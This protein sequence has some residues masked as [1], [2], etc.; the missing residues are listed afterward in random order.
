MLLILLC[1]AV[2]V[3]PGLLVAR[4]AGLPGWT[5][6]GA[7]PLVSYGV[8]ATAGPVTSA[9]GIPWRPVTMLV[10]TAV[11][12]GL[13]WSIRSLFRRQDTRAL[14]PPDRRGDWVIAAGVVAGAVLGA[15]A[16]MR[17]IG[18]LEA[19]HQGWDAG[20]HAN[21]IRF[22]SDTGDASPGALRALNNYEDT[23]FFYPNAQHVLTS[24]AGQLSGS[25]MP[26]LLNVQMLF[27]PGLAGLGLAVL[28]RAYG[29]RV[30]LAASVPLV[31]ASFSG[32]PYDLLSRGPLLP[33]A[34]GVALLPG[35]LVLLNR[36]L[37][38]ARAPIVLVTV[39]AA[40]GLFAV[41]PS[42]AVTASIFVFPMLVHRWWPSH[43]KQRLWEAAT[44]ATVASVAALAGLPF[45]LGALAVGED[46]ALYWPANQSPG[47]AVA[48]IF[49][50]DHGSGVP[51]QGLV[52]L[53]LVGLLGL[54]A[55]RRLWWW[56]T[57]GVVFGALFVAAASS[58]APVL[59]ALTQPW[60]NDRW[61][62]L[63]V[64]IMT[65][66][67][68]AAQGAVVVGDLLA[69]LAQRLARGRAATP[70]AA[71]GL[72]RPRLAIGVAMVAVLATFGLTSNSFY[73]PVN[74]TQV[75]RNYQGGPAV[76][77]SEQTAMRALAGMAGTEGRVMNDP[78]DGSSWMYA[79]EGV[80]PIFGH[81]VDPG[82]FRLIGED[83]QLLLSSFNCL[84]SSPE[85]RQLVDKYDI[86]YV[87]TGQGYLRDHFRRIPGLL[88]LDAV[89]S[90]QLMY[91]DDG[92]AIYQVRLAAM[93]D[94]P[95]R[96]C[97][98]LT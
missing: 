39:V 77:A 92:T 80:R 8:A 84:D 26:S 21:A 37:S 85:V 63:A 12:A 65:L 22:I 59:E 55:L 17:G 54:G 52:A 43:A 10:A 75:N 41:H 61:R 60:W 78:Q 46:G 35:F 83:Q 31:L 94:T 93:S 50:L 20:F 30:A 15:V 34:T 45:F 98:A 27:L 82:R 81:V 38:P 29:G 70:R 56:L 91:A 86:R 57:G 2:V 90:L 62:L 28:V 73:I 69:G 96:S 4:A 79:L 87:F 13:L 9:V 14:A 71:I 19:V 95:S 6:L 11:L 88:N 47:Q 1:A 5:C 23:T 18:G 44:L 24:I 58:D 40:A 76:T 53:L 7:A 66:A 89:G 67:V 36:A 68:V 42:T 48:S 49:L 97:E 64:V 3:L 51:Q 25:S 74:E 33:Y 16:I 32:F 72:A